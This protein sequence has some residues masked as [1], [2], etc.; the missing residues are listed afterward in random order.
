MRFIVKNSCFSAQ[1]KDI[2]AIILFNINIC[3]IKYQILAMEIVRNY[4]NI[5]NKQQDAVLALGNFDGLHLGHQAILNKTI[6]AAKENG[7]KSAVMSFEP[8]PIELLQQKNNIRIFSLQ[9][10]I[11]FIAAAG[12]DILFLFRFS[13]KFAK[14]PAA[15]FLEDILISKLKTHHIII[16]HD[17]IFGHKRSGNAIYLKN[18]AK[19]LN[20]KFT[21]IEP[22]IHQN[23]SGMIYSSTKIRNEL[24]LGNVQ[25]AAILL[26]KNYHITGRVIS[27]NNMGGKLGYKTANLALDNLFRIKFGV[28][29]VKIHYDDK[30]YDGVANIGIRPS[31]ADNKEFLEVHIF[32]FCDNIYGKKISVEFIAF[33]RPEKKFQNLEEL[34]QQIAAD[35]TLANQ[36]LNNNEKLY[37]S[38]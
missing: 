30:I 26:G 1:N 38:P 13:S 31:F 12:I 8:H 19:E 4:H 25:N 36:L 9:S 16:G 34:K 24:Q 17:F 33:I 23:H 22:V 35:C 3:F 7:K 18:R 37:S 11:K 21:Q 5:T 32:N 20:Y 15:E 29:A 14:L 28:Y 2:V 27:G 10:K 6:A